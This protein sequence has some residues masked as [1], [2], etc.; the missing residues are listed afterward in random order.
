MKDFELVI[1]DVGEKKEGLRVRAEMV[2]QKTPEQKNTEKLKTDTDA[3]RGWLTANPGGFRTYGQLAAQLGVRKERVGPVVESMMA[4][5]EVVRIG[6][7]GDYMYQL[8]SS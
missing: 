7:K 6:P 3:I 2:E 8:R 4:A 1:E 5:G